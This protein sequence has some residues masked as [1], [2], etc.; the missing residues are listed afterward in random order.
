MPTHFFP[1]TIL[2]Q[3]LEDETFL[4]EALNF[5]EISRFHTKEDS[6]KHS[7]RVNAEAILKSDYAPNLYARITPENAKIEEIELEI[8]PPK[9]L[10]RGAMRSK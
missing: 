6:A 1:L 2:T 3:H 10:R 4:S 9:K 5:S 8:E 7:A